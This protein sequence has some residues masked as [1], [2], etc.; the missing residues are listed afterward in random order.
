MLVVACS[1]TIDR[2]AVVGPEESTICQPLPASG[3][4]ILQLAGNFVND[5]AQLV[6]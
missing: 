1:R 5:D 3:S 4:V 2:Q 6:R